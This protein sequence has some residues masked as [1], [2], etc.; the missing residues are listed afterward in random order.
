[1]T[2]EE[3]LNE[4]NKFAKQIIIHILRDY[5]DS[6]GLENELRL[7]DLLTKDFVV[8]DSVTNTDISD[9]L[10][11]IF[12]DKEDLIGLTNEEMN[13][14]IKKDILV[15]EIFRYIITPKLENETNENNK[16]FSNDLTEGLIL[17]YATDFSLRHDL[18]K[19][20]LRNNKNI[21]LATKLLEG[22]PKDISKD[23]LFFQYQ[24][25]FM[26]NYYK[27]GT[28]KD[29]LKEYYEENNIKFEMP[30]SL[31]LEKKEPNSEYYKNGFLRGSYIILACIILGF[32]LAYFLVR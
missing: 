29:F 3:L 18:G 30:A 15:K 23:A 2:R 10:V 21:I 7:R 12:I 6:L 28:G 5:Q 32:F 4:L 14:K 8:L 19:P 17:K 20:N 25:P 27:I 24:Y 13:I 31:V 11:H 9:N 1:M 16:Q 26:L 22:L